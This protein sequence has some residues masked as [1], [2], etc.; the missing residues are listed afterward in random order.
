[1]NIYGVN[2]ICT[3]LTATLHEP[4]NSEENNEDFKVHPFKLV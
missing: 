3:F 2:L 4:E 1:M